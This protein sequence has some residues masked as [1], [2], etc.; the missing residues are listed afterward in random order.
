MKFR[1]ANQRQRS[2]RLVLHIAIK[3]S[4]GAIG[5]VISPIVRFARTAAAAA[6][7]AAAARARA[8]PIG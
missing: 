8:A 1:R 2:S 3:V 7:A 5:A 6:A 4:S